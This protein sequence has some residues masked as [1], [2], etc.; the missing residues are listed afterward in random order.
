MRMR[1]TDVIRLKHMFNAAEEAI[2]FA[3]GASRKTLNNDRMLVL[4]LIKDIE[5][6]GEAASRISPDTQRAM[7]D[8]PW[9][10]IKK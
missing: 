8:I 9:A 7:P 5:I 6:V 2:S 1:K 10:N 4:S 3:V